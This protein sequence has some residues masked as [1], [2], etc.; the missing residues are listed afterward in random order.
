MDLLGW[1]KE[2]GLAVTSP[3]G[4][5]L[6]NHRSLGAWE[7]Q[8]IW[9]NRVKLHVGSDEAVAEGMPLPFPGSPGTVGVASASPPPRHPIC[10]PGRIRRQRE[11]ALALG[12]RLG[13]G[14]MR[15]GDR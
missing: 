8:A 5:F 14:I 3:L 12:Q 9:I 10:L 11:A 4:V 1:A 15:A 13:P 2:E 7:I 6:E